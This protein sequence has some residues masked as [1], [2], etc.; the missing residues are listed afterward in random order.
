MGLLAVSVYF[1]ITYIKEDPIDDL[2]KHSYKTPEVTTD[3]QDGSFV[4][5]QFQVVTDG[6]KAKDEI[7]KR[8]FQLQNILIKE[9]AHYTGEEFA[10]DL[11]QL[12]KTVQEK[13]NEIMTEGKV[14][15]VYTVNKI[16]Q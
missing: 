16:L 12:E 5:I 10:T 8:D 4:K 2:V 9:L 15:D 14:I 6:K 11:D 13:L 7:S 3:L 1:I